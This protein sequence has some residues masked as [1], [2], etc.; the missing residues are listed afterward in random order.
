M[1]ADLVGAFRDKAEV[2]EAGIV[3]IRFPVVQRVVEIV[4]EPDAQLLKLALAHRRA[5]RTRGNAEKKTNEQTP[6]SKNL[7][8]SLKK[9]IHGNF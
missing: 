4:R 8:N 7:R 5:S 9:Q 3:A 1:A 2:H 6:L